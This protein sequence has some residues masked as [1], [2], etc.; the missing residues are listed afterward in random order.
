MLLSN[1][2]HHGRSSARSLQPMLR[3]GICFDH[4]TH[5]VFLL[6]K[7]LSKSPLFPTII[8]RS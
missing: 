7:V 5:A 3:L 6:Y 2:S 1:E 4:F 8:M